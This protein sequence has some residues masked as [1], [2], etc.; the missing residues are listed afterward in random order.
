MSFVMA[1]VSSLL[2]AARSVG[3]PEHPGSLF[4]APPLD[5][6]GL[7]ERPEQNSTN[8]P[9]SFSAGVRHAKQ[10]TGFELAKLL[11]RETL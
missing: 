8:H 7:I 9:K 11:R 1:S 10:A 5:S 2:K 3:E 4:T 6:T